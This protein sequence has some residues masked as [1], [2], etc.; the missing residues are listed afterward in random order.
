ME[1]ACR[2]FAFGEFSTY[3]VAMVLT[4]AYFHAGSD[5]IDFR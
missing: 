1:T 5:K 4:E 3:Y 2:I